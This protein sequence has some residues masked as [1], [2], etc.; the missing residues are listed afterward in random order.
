[1]T[2]PV[3][4]VATFATGSP[5]TQLRKLRPSPRIQR[6]LRPFPQALLRKLRPSP[7][8]VAVLAVVTSSPSHADTL[9]VGIY[10]P[11]APFEGTAARV[12]VANK[13]A[14]ALASASLF[15]TST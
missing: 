5:L 6:E 15:A 12:E 9:T 7:L 10:A 14:D 11:A 13:L 1:M 2:R 8:I 3:G 4:T